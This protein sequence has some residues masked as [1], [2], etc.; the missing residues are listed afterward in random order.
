MPT[1]LYELA[2]WR[3]PTKQL[4]RIAKERERASRR[5]NRP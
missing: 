2:G 1:L 3:V 4:E 5:T